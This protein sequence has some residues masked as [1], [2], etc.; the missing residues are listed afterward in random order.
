MLLRNKNAVIY[1][2]GGAIGGAVARAFSQE[3]AKVFLVGRNINRLNIV[4]KEITDHG[5]EVETAQV[6]ALDEEA[7]ENHL[8]QVVNRFGSVDVSFN[9]IG[10]GETQGASLVEMEQ[11]QFVS[12]IITAMQSHFITTTAA[13]RHMAKQKAGVILALT[14]QAA[15]KPYR[16]VGGFG[17]A[18]AAIEGLC[19][20][21]AIEVGPLGIR[22]VCLRSAGSP[23]APGV[24]EVFNRHADN[25][26]ITRDEFEAG[27]AEKTMLKRLPRL[28]EVANAAV[29]MASD[30]ASAITGAVANVTCGEI[31][32]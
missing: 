8:S 9:L 27:I 30:H 19:R 15:R 10:L 1:G 20:Q 11:E 16:D 29:L 25:A 17:V 24:D 4:A 26:G 32:D 13:A 3:G 23:D 21:L 28:A 7:V 12:P 2:A 6:N 14:A 5:G 18:G 22:V 31:V